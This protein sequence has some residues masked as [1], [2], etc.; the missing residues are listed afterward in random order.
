MN[1]VGAIKIGLG[2]LVGYLLIRKLRATKEA[3][4]VITSE[5]GRYVST[6]DPQKLPVRVLD[7]V[8]WHINEPEGGIG[9][10]AV[11]ELRFKN[12]DSPLFRKVPKD[13]KKPG[14]RKI[15]D[16]VRPGTKRPESY[17]YEVWYVLGTTEYR[18]ED[19]EIQVEMN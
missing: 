7:S 19:P 4:I 5:N 14:K 2:A 10:E 13:D 16:T 8:L 15:R 17:C 11:V 3:C 18:M 6:T 1:I 9:A 12:D